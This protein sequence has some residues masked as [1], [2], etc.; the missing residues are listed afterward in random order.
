MLLSYFV[1]FCIFEQIRDYRQAVLLPKPSVSISLQEPKEISCSSL[2]AVMVSLRYAV[3]RFCTQTVTS[4]FL[5]DGGRA[6][7]LSLSA[8]D[9]GMC[10]HL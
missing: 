2:A 7:R 1:C 8:T 10:V 9:S 4:S 6:D 3:T 5:L